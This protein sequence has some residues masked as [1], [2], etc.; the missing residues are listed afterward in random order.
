[1][2]K[3]II[4]LFLA[5]TANWVCAQKQDTLRIRVMTYNLRFGELASLEQIAEHIKAF[6][7]DFVALQEVDSKTF[8]ERTPQQNGKD[9]ITELGYRTQMY[10]LYGKSISYKGGYYGIGIL[11]RHPYFKSE[12]MML[13]RP[14]EKEQRVMF[15]GTF[16]VNGKDTITF[17]CTHLDYFSEDTRFLQIKKITET[18]Q[19]SPYPVILGGDFNTRPDSKTIREGISDWKLLTNDDLTFPSNKPSIK[20]DYLFGYPKDVWRVI[21]TQSIQSLLSDHLPIITEVELIRETK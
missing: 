6:Q 1:M 21:R 18:L 15:Q 19:R 3:Y 20:I 4:V 2:K 10:P 12:K 11:S 17:A 13:P 8:R 5:L 16:E 7:P 9:F 14:Q